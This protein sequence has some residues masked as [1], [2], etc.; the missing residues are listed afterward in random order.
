MHYSIVDIH[1]HVW[2]SKVAEKARE[3]LES[4]FKV[5]LKELPTVETLLEFMDKNKI[6]LSCIC[7]VAPDPGKVESINNWLFG[8]KNP[9]LG[10]FAAFHP[11]YK[12]WQNEFKRIKDNACGIKLQ[13]EFQN[14]YV[15]ERR[16]FP[17]YEEIEKL[18]IPVLFHCG[19]ELSG[20][21]IVRSSP[22]RLLRVK[23]SF[24][25]LKIIAAHFG[26]F[27]L[28]D[29]VEKYLL[30]TDIYLDTSFFF[31]YLPSQRIKK[32]LLGHDK[33]RLLFGTDFPLIDQ[34]K[35]IDYLKNLDIPSQL[36]KVI[37]SQNALKLLKL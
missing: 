14:F 25:S 20:T 23:Q 37:F 6:R 22:E 18:G 29:D 13:P 15:D 12:N 24:P 27:R 26:G 2:P 28:W 5:K 8:I 30:G 31:H 9:R 19:Y 36:K 21:M 34:K 1:T 33:N 17:I 11:D 32:M 10:I 16:V 35:D 4:L 7:S 3:N